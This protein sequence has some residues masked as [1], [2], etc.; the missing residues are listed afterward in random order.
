MRLTERMED[1]TYD[2]KQCRDCVSFNCIYCSHLTKAI[3]RL[4]ELEDIENGVMT[5]KREFT[6]STT[7]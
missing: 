2:V 1:G 4:G 7:A 6:V 5:K 3:Q